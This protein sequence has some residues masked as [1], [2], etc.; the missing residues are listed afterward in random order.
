VI[1]RF[2]HHDTPLAS[3]S[4]NENKAEIRYKCFPAIQGMDSGAESC[5]RLSTMAHSIHRALVFIDKIAHRDAVCSR[6]ASSDAL[7]P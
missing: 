3:E 7:M 5:E 1:F 4:S 2:F 6:V